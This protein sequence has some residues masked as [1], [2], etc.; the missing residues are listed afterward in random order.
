MTFMDY[1]KAFDP[2]ETSIVMNTLRGQGV[3]EMYVKILEDIYKES[4]ATMMLHKVSDIFPM[5]EGVR[6]GDTIS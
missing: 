5:Q 1:E 4:T 6:Q 2:V 3:Q